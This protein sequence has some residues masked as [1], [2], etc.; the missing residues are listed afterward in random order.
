MAWMWI[1][2]HP[3]RTINQ[4]EL[5]IGCRIK[6]KPL[7]MPHNLLCFHLNNWC[8]VRVFLTNPE[9]LD[10]VQS[11]FHPRTRLMRVKRS[12]KKS[13]CF[14]RGQTQT[15]AN[16]HIHVASLVPQCTS[17]CL[18]NIMKLIHNLEWIQETNKL[19]LQEWQCF[20]VSRDNTHAREQLMIAA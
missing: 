7:L 3:S 17:H 15:T 1:K 19:F 9:R 12:I 14:W 11:L 16:Y 6:E 5:H 10:D 18:N 4:G 20:E 8:G 2:W 13:P